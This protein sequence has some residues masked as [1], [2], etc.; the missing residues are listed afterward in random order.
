MGQP[1]TLAKKTIQQVT[2]LTPPPPPPEAP[3]PPPPEEKVEIEEPEPE[4]EVADAEQPPAGDQL[5]LDAD[6]AAGGDAFGLLARKGG[7]DLLAGGGDDRFGWYSSVLKGD[8]IGRLSAIRDIRKDRYNVS[9]RLWL[10]P[11]GRVQRYR[12]VGTT[13]KADLDRDLR[14]ALDSLDRVSERP[15]EGLPQPVRLR[16]VSRI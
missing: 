13:G 7:R 16:I 8:L 3:P 5:G 12:L 6:G 9:V 14:A 4:P 10:S 15:P 2:I 11:D 1:V